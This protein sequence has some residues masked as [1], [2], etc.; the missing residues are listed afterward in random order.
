MNREFGQTVKYARKLVEQTKTEKIF[1][2]INV[3][4]EK[5]LFK[6]FSNQS[7]ESEYSVSAFLLSETYLL[8]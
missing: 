4:E 1:I 6:S 5:Q 7:C 3:I 8:Y 2:S